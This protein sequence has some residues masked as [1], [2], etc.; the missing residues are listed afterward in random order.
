MVQLIKSFLL[1]IGFLNSGSNLDMAKAGKKK[2]RR[3]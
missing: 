1:T 3:I 2:A